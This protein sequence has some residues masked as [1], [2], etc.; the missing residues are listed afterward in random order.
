MLC[1]TEW[2]TPE[3]SVLLQVLFVNKSARFVAGGNLPPAT[4]IRGDVDACSARINLVDT[5]LLPALV[6]HRLSPLQFLLLHLHMLIHDRHL[7]PCS[8]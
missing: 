8:D 5:V 3:L 6:R 1:C 7:G 2:C 4:V